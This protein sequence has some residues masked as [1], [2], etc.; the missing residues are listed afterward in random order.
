MKHFFHLVCLGLLFAQPLKAQ[1]PASITGASATTTTATCPS[2]GVITVSSNVINN[3]SAMYQIIEGPKD[4]NGQPTGYTTASQ[5]SNSFQALPPGTYT[6]R[7]T[8]GL[9]LI[10]I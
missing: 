6:I 8:C 3:A 7:I 1:C 5:S 10:H 2:N 9:S 4:A